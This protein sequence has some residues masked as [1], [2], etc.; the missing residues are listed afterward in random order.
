M[1]IALCL[2]VLCHSPP[3]DKEQGLGFSVLE[4][5][6]NNKMVVMVKDIVLGGPAYRDGHLQ[7]G[8]ILLSVNGE[9]VVG[10]PYNV[11]SVVHNTGH[12]AVVVHK[13]WTQTFS[14]MCE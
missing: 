7:V 8:D 1:C 3:Q 4:E 2:S 14:C 10:K 6:V 11:V 13:F 12:Q 5:E 9:S